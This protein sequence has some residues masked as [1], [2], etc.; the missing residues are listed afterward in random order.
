MPPE[1]TEVAHPASTEAPQPSK[2]LN[3]GGSLLGRMGQRVERFF[4]HVTPAD[5]IA[6]VLL[7]EGSVIPE[8]G[9]ELLFATTFQ[10]KLDFLFGQAAQQDSPSEVVNHEDG[11]ILVKEKATGKILAADFPEQYDTSLQ[12][13]T[14]VSKL[15]IEQGNSLYEVTWRGCPD[16]EYT[17]M[18]TLSKLKNNK[19]QGKQYTV[20]GEKQSGYTVDYAKLAP[21]S[22][23]ADA[24][25]TRRGDFITKEGKY[26]LAPKPTSKAA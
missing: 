11:S 14:N 23:I 1:I 2:T 10:S 22:S 16:G 7:G 26:P 12:A 6:E 19:H 5:E 17:D 9:A 4:S 21:L 20:G 25:A 8:Q 18:F 15:F 13:K 3:R 24:R